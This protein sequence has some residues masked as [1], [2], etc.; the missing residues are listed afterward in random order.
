MTA[1]FDSYWDAQRRVD[2]AWI[3]PARWQRMSILN[4]A[5]MAWFSSDRAIRDYAEDIWTV[6]VRAGT[7]GL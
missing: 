7:R 1:D 5:K 2:S 3:D 4:T 6:P